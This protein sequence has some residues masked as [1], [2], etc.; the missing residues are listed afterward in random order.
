MVTV[1]VLTVWAACTVCCAVEN[2]GGTGSVACCKDDGGGRPDQGP[3]SP[4]HCI[5]SFINSGG[6]VSQDTTLSIPVPLDGLLVFAAEPQDADFPTR[7][8]TVEPALSPPGA[9]K[10]WQFFFRAALPARAPSLVS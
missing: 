9:L 4:E 8:G 6:Y 10:P 2:M 5:C 1:L 7:P 3:A